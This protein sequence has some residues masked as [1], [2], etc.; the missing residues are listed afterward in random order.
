MNI[1]V[2]IIAIKTS[3]VGFALPHGDSV[4]IN[5]SGSTTITEGSLVSIFDGSRLIFTGESFLLDK[6][7]KLSTSYSQ[8]SN[9]LENLGRG[10]HY[11]LLSKKITLD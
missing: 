6:K 2:P 3:F 5:S 4:M 11:R 9:P 7:S 1:R 10:T 8:Q